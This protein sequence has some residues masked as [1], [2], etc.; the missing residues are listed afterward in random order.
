V[1]S[2]PREFTFAGSRLGAPRGDHR[3]P[4]LPRPSSGAGFGRSPMHL[5]VCMSF[6]WSAG[7]GIVK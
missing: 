5:F 6:R 1:I 4:H 2:S 3:Q 7:N